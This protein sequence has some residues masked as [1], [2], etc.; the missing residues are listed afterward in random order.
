MKKINTRFGEVEYQESNLLVFPQGLIGLKHL[1]NFVVMPNTKESP[2]FW[3][4]SVD[5]PAMAFVLTNPQDFFRDYVVE[6]QA[7][8]R[9]TLDVTEEDD[10]FILTVV[11]VPPNQEITLNLAAPILFAPKSNR[12]LQVI[13]S[14]DSHSSKTPLPQVKEKQE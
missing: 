13:L 2:L 4:Q 3:I 14:A 10:I 9:N 6:I 7:E 12:A 1:K 8:E 11:T 5:D